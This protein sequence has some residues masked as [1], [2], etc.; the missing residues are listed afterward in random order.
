[1]ELAFDP[2]NH[3]YSFAVGDRI[4][5]LSDEPETFA[6]KQDALR[7]AHDH[8]LSVSPWGMVTAA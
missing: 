8:N 2:R 7:A 6:T 4:V 3:T 1:M 5:P